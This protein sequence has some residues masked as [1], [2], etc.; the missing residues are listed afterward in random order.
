MFLLI[1][2]MSNLSIICAAQVQI[3]FLLVLV[4]LLVLPTWSQLSTHA[5]RP[6][7]PTPIRFRTT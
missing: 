7:C 2:L 6:A 5:D 1:L 3:N 4:L